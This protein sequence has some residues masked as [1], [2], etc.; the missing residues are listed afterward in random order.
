MADIRRFNPL[1]TMQQRRDLCVTRAPH[2]AKPVD[3]REPQSPEAGAGENHSSPKTM[4]TPATT[5]PTFAA[6]RAARSTSLDM[7]PQDAPSSR[8]HL[9]ASDDRAPSLYGPPARSAPAIRAQFG[10]E[11]GAFTSLGQACIRADVH[12]AYWLTV[13]IFALTL[14]NI[15]RPPYLSLGRHLP[16]N[17]K[18]HRRRCRR[19]RTRR[20][21]RP[22]LRPVSSRTNEVFPQHALGRA[23]FAAH[24]DSG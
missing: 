12:R 20:L 24:S 21:V 18:A 13:G 22:M 6:C 4:K 23:A 19:T 2:S 17:S 3:E 11:K 9:I 14:L 16:G 15:A 1:V 10:H 7:P 5:C 8:L